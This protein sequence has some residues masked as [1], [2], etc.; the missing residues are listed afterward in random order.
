ME[1]AMN[2]SVTTGR[3]HVENVLRFAQEADLREVFILGRRDDGELYA[4]TSAPTGHDDEVIAQMIV[5]FQARLD[6]GEY[7]T[8]EEV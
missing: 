7:E 5:E 6:D 1:N 4:A 2:E 8:D 3:V